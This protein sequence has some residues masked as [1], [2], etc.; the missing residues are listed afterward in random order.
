MA[1]QVPVVQITHRRCKHAWTP[2]GAL[3]KEC[4]GC[5]ARINQ[6]EVDVEVLPKELLT[7]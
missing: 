6:G 7:K 1:V 5:H 4:P 3:I 2:R